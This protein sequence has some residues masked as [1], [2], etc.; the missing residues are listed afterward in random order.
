MHPAVTD[1]TDEYPF[2]LG[3]YRREVSTT[4]PEAAEWFRRGLIWTYA[5][6]HEEA[7]G[8]FVRSAQADPGF[9]LAH[10]GAAYVLGPNYNKPWADF[11]PEDLERSLAHAAEHTRRA[12]DLASD[13]PAV[14]RAII[15]TLPHRYPAEQPPAGEDW[16]EQWVLGYAEACRELYRDHPDDLDVIAIHLDALLGVRP[17]ELWDL[18][19]GEPE[20]GVPTLEA[21]DVADRALVDPQARQHPGVL[22]MAIH[23]MEMSGQPET[24]LWVADWARD[25][26]PDGGHLVHMP[27]HIDV[28]CG[29]Y[30]RVIET[31]ERAVQA[32]ERYL[33]ARGGENFYTLY[34]AH[35][36]HFVMYGAMFL[37]QSQKAIDAG[38]RLEQTLPKELLTVTSPP[39]A[40]WLE[41]FYP[42][43]MHALIRFGRWQEILDEPLPED[44]NLFCTTTAV[45]HYAKGVASAALGDVEAARDHRRLFHAAVERVPHSRTVFN[46]TCRDILE[47]AAAML[48]GEIEYRAGNHD[49]AFAHL[50]RSVELDDSLPY[51]EPWSWMQPTRHA[52]AALLMEQGRLDDAEQVYRE[53]LGYEPS[54]P[55]ANLHPDNVWSLHGY[56]ECLVR[57]GADEL[58]SVVKRRLKIVRAQ[59]DVPVTAS[60]AC[61]L[62]A[63]GP[64]ARAA[65]GPLPL[66]FAAA[67][68]ESGG[69]CT[70]D[71]SADEGCDQAAEDTDGACCENPQ[72]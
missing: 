52:L 70:G 53:D 65:A 15:A 22:H 59:A 55:R 38:R 20:P 51:D 28:L 17:W 33:A 42:M 54:I 68:T 7:Y 13:A 12:L 27:T 71:A 41:G 26:V 4:D 72:A 67:A 8:C 45:M 36:L 3:S 47:V 5:F 63:M 64:T 21:K 14:E 62:E 24:A 1:A 49:E 30:R 32:D 9:A 11:D 35:N 18:R 44:Q 58:A 66:G 50:R 43:T 39:M 34:R 2:D 31:N 40:D 6:N 57:R 29:D 48:D 46:N 56:H 19:T 37:G 10:W 61:R 16:P 60:C 23:L 25:V 69:C